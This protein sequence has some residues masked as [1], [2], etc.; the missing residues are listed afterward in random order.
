[1]G[2]FYRS[3]PHTEEEAEYLVSLLPGFQGISSTEYTTSDLIKNSDIFTAV[4]MI[5]SD[6]AKMDIHVIKNG[7]RDKKNNSIE[8]LLNKRPNQLYDGYVFKMIVF[9]NA[10]LTKHG[11]VEIIRDNHTKQP[12]ELHHLKTS[13]VE[14]K[15]DG[16]GALHY[17][18]KGKRK[19][20]YYDLIDYKPYT[21][22]GFSGLSP[23]ESLKQDLDMQKQSKTFFANYFKN[24]T[25][26]GG[27]LKLKNGKVS[28]EARDVIRKEFQEAYAGASKA[29][30][31]MV[32]DETMDYDAIEIDTEILKL[33]NTSQHST[34]QVAKNFGIP[35][36]KFGIETTN[37]S[38]KDSMADYLQSTL[39]TYIK[40]I[41]SAFAF[42]LFS[43]DHRELEFDTETYR[44]ADWE[45][46]AKTLR[47][48]L[49]DGAIT[50][51]E[52]RKKMGYAPIDAE[53]ANKHRVSLNQVNAE[54]VDEYQKATMDNRL[55]GADA[56]LKG[57]EIDEG[58]GNQESDADD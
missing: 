44:K 26:A 18:H 40:G 43:Y 20:D 34:A 2:L 35:I 22:D 3:M 17:L 27:L 24:G 51:N 12:K 23:L 58:Q 54:I 25:Q 14:L 39:S 8:M 38:L 36:H 52:Y 57:G 30:G 5:A 11:Y 45:T 47:E 15:K 13:E 16:N 21:L 46:Y 29:G 31:V 19:I 53:Y 48:D 55:K 28:K 42:K 4:M 41:T 50:L 56:T 32:M 1:M 49:K 9:S 33:I 37:M 7:E 6:L 10:L